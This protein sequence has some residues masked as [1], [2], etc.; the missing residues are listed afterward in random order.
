MS[1]SALPD[2]VPGNTNPV[3]SPS[4][5]ACRRMSTARADSGSTKGIVDSTTSGTDGFQYSLSQVNAST[6]D[7]ATYGKPTIALNG[8]VLSD[9]LSVNVS[10]L[11]VREVKIIFSFPGHLEHQFCA[12]L[13]ITIPVGD[14]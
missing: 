9:F 1:D 3:P 5:L 14:I 4:A 8:G 2:F 12:A 11:M 6:W 10:E 13:Q 7:F